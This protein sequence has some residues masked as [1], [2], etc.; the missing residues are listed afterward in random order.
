MSSVFGLGQRAEHSI[1]EYQPNSL[2]EFTLEIPE[3]ALTILEFLDFRDH[4]ALRVN[5][6]LYTVLEESESAAKAWAYFKCHFP[7]SIPQSASNL[8][9][10]RRESSPRFDDR[11]WG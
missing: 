5:R 7:S 10:G 9:F 1:V 4:S 11:K 6:F 2:A 3:L 8:E